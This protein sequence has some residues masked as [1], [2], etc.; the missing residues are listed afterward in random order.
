MIPS[1]LFYSATESVVHD[2]LYTVG[3]VNDS[4]PSILFGHWVCYPWS[5][6]YGGDGEWFHPIYSIRPLS[7]LSMILCIRWGWWMIPSHLFCS[8]TES[9]VLDPLYTMG[10]VNDSIPSILFGHWVC[11]P[12]SFEYNG[13]SEWFHPIYSVWPLSLLSLIQLCRLDF[14]EDGLMSVCVCVPGCPQLWYGWYER[15]HHGHSL[16]CK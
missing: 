16:C 3:I 6:V 1:H 7:L 5:F 2:P 14:T 15:L 8:A 10:I 11:C 4:I 9:V 12:W 13:D